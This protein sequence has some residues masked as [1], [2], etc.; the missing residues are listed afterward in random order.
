MPE[1]Q[2][3]LFDNLPPTREETPVHQLNYPTFAGAEN[4]M[5]HGRTAGVDLVQGLSVSRP[6]TND[7]W[8]P[9]RGHPVHVGTFEAAAH[10]GLGEHKA[11]PTMRD[12]SGVSNIVHDTY[13]S[14]EDLMEAAGTERNTQMLPFR[15]REDQM[16]NT[17]DMPVSDAYANLAEGRYGD[18]AYEEEYAD[19]LIASGVVDPEEA[20]ELSSTIGPMMDFG[21]YAPDPISESGG[22][23]YRNTEEDV[24]SVS[25]VVPSAK[26]LQHWPTEVMEH[27]TNPAQRRTAE[28]LLGRGY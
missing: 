14:R 28:F 17:P 2:P 27:S 20:E 16:F 21:E 19:E 15:V 12:P 18:G 5:W 6:F 4:T 1:L 23:Y 7:G 9:E 13:R 10:R 3:R 24:G 26:D 22:L 11:R 8:N 25:A